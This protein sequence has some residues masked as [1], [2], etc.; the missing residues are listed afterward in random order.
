MSTVT[1]TAVFTLPDVQARVVPN[2]GAP[3]VLERRISDSVKV[4]VVKD[5]PASMMTFSS[6][7]DNRA[8]DGQ[9]K[10]ETALAIALQ[11]CLP[12]LVAG[13]GMVGAGIYLDIVQ[14]NNDLKT[15]RSNI[16]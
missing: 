4:T 8:P 9:K 16:I 6:G 5:T 15:L 11:V 2:D 13:M 12:F 10:Q 14:V 1:P 7:G 3:P